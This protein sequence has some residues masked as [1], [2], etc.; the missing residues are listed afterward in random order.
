[1]AYQ[2]DL[3]G[4]VRESM[5]ADIRRDRKAIEDRLKESWPKQRV[6]QMRR[7][8]LSG[9]KLHPDVRRCTVDLFVAQ[10]QHYKCRDWVRGAHLSEF[11]MF[12]VRLDTGLALAD[13]AF[14]APQ[15]QDNSGAR[16]T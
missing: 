16:M 11:F 8:S 10:R 4:E 15:G 5:V 14:L 6:W 3:E 9:G 7:A 13:T 12:T 1:M 2:R